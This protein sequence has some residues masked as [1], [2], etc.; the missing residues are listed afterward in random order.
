ME[1]SN[2]CEPV[3]GA[4]PDA[5]EAREY[6]ESLVRWIGPGFHPDSDFADYVH[7]KTGSILFTATQAAHLNWSLERAIEVLQHQDD[8]VYDIALPIQRAMLAPL[9]EK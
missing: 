5:S 3:L 2:Q 8:D 4:N 6:V 9:F 1:N 7:A